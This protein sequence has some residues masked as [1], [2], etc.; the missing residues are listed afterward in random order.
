MPK[1]LCY[2]T[3]PM[4]GRPENNF[5][6]FNRWAA[7]LRSYGV[8]VLNPAEFEEGRATWQEYI[9]RDLR[10]MDIEQPQ[11]LFKLEGHNQSKGGQVEL[12]HFLEKSYGKLVTGYDENWAVRLD[13]LKKELEDEADGVD[14]L[15]IIDAKEA[16]EPARPYG[17]CPV[18]YYPGISRERRPN[19]DDYCTN[20]H[21]YPSK[22]ALTVVEVPEQPEQ[23][24]YPIT[25]AEADKKR[26]ETQMYL[27]SALCDRISRTFRELST[28]ETT[29]DAAYLAWDVDTH[30]LME[31]LGQ[32]MEE[33]NMF[34]EGD[35]WMDAI[36]DSA[37]GA[38]FDYP[39]SEQAGWELLG[40]AVQSVGTECCENGHCFAPM[41]GGI[42]CQACGEVRM[43]DNKKED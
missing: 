34:E 13:R 39:D 18:C 4:R 22:D 19:G 41:E 6:E 7:I 9:D 38:P 8:D 25:Y 32:F 20:G 43:N 24:P 11:V 35:E 31:S 28:L 36:F 30:E 17:F 16:K 26:I 40:E 33:R 27:V 3:G 5:P 14:D 1:L 29:E 10:I 12:T 2:L 42:F 23:T 15:A 21:G 37:G